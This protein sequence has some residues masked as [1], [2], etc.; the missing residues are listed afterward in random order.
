MVELQE[1]KFS[2]D[3]FFV[4]IYN[5]N[6][7]RESGLISRSVVKYCFALFNYSIILLTGRCR[8]QDYGFNFHIL[9]VMMIKSISYSQSLLISN[10]TSPLSFFFAKNNLNVILLQAAE[11]K[12][13]LLCHII[14]S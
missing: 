11:K 8:R 5:Q 4:L 3:K 6:L 10:T 2:K 7:I 9:D 13:S 12:R 1:G 14:L